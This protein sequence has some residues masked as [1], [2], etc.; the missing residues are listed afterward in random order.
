MS[1]VLKAIQAAKF[2]R[3]GQHC[4][5]YFAEI[6]VG[7]DLK[8]LLAP[9]Y[10][11]HVAGTFRGKYN[12]ITALW[13]DKSRMVRL[14]VRFYSQ[15]HAFVEVLEDHVFEDVAEGD[16][17]EAYDVRWVNDRDR[18]AVVRKQDA[19]LMRNGFNTKKDALGFISTTL[20]VA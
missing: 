12:E 4:T 3:D 19:Q 14:F 2:H 20:K 18:Y 10:W 11:S 7:T 1:N 5:R 8:D 17:P 9:V 16:I 6:P 13:D 15:T